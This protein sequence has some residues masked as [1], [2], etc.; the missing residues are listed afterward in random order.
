[1]KCLYCDNETEYQPV[2]AE[3]VEKAWKRKAKRLGVDLE[4]YQREIDRTA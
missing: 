4:W 3:C 1:M 2:C